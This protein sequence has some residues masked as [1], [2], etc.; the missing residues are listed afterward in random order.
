MMIIVNYLLIKRIIIKICDHL[1]RLKNC[2]FYQKK[3][4]KKKQLPKNS[5]NFFFSF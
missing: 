1:I 3:K 5:N 2:L 4:K